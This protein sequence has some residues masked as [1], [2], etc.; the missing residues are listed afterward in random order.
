M[1]PGVIQDIKAAVGAATGLSRDALQVY[2][3]LAVC[4]ATLAVTSIRSWKP[5]IAVLV[6][7]CVG[8]L[9]N[10]RD[11]VGASTPWHWRSALH[12]LCN[13]LF[14]PTVV[15]LLARFTRLWRA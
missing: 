2:V 4:L 15:L 7:A 12:G 14:W 8:E 11:A 6:V 1:H 10:L 5:W 13:E 9:L 3:G